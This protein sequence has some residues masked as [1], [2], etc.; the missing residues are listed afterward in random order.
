MKET[1]QK[2]KIEISRFVYSDDF[3]REIEY[4]SKIHQY[5]DR[6]TFKESWKKWIEEENIKPLIEYEIKNA[7]EK[8]YKGDI[9]DK[10]Y[11]SARYYYRKKKLD[12]FKKETH[13]TEEEDGESNY[14]GLSK[15]MIKTMDS[16]IV[17]I[18]YCNVESEDKKINKEML[19]SKTK[20]SNA[21]DNFCKNYIAEITR[22]IYRLKEKIILEPR[23]ISLKFKKAYKNRFYKIRLMLE[24]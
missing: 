16:H 7:A 3:T 5:E 11:K 22:E 21:F 15:E 14:A 12:V 13:N 10:I 24:N 18:V 9:M 8:G 4:F 23:E 6:K 17:Y 2:I 1:A 20:A 19:I